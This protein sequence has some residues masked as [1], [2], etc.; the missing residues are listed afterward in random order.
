MYLGKIKLHVC[1]DNIIIGLLGIVDVFSRDI[2]IEFGLDKC[3]IY[4]FWKH[5]QE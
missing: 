4:I 5:Q 1:T 3:Q 2:Q